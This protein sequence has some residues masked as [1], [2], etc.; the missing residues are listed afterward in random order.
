MVCAGDR[1]GWRRVLLLYRFSRRGA[2][3][4]SPYC[5]LAPIARARAAIHAPFAHDRAADDT[6]HMD[7]S[8]TL[9]FVPGNRERML[10]RAATAGA[11]VIVVD[12]EDAVPAAE[13]RAARALTRS[14]LQRLADAGQTVFV[15]V[16]GVQTG[17]TRADVQAVVRPG[18]AGVVLPKAGQAQD[19]RDLDVLLREAELARRIRP[20]NVRTLPIIESA[21]GLLRCEEIA[22]ASDRLVGLSVG[23]EDYTAELGVPGD[24]RTTALA[25]LRYT[26]VQVAVAYSL[27]PIDTP[28]ADTRDADGLAAEARLAR[29][30]GFRGKYVIHPGQVEAVNAAFTPSREELA[31]ARRVVRAAET[32]AKRGR[33]SVSLD[34][35]M[36]DAPVVARARRLLAA[37][38]A[39][40]ARN[41]VANPLLRGVGGA[42]VPNQKRAAALAA[43]T[44]E[45]S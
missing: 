22:R 15:R 27:V 43:V 6:R 17:L 35:R 9:L 44:E 1:A 38:S 13:K 36:V 3:P 4:R 30:M 14:W 28:F 2:H 39:I 32:G 20:G 41:R 33:G 34:G 21:C 19:L 45:S 40:E 8:R 42:S 11:D 25:H 23:G 18:L 29:A 37:A 7:L 12:L 26:V 31:E 10:A 5:F 24:A 16:N